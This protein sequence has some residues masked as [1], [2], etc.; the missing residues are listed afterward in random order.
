MKFTI[1]VFPRPD[2]PFRGKCAF[3]MQPV[4]LFE[5]HHHVCSLDIHKLCVCRSVLSPASLPP[6]FPSFKFAAVWSGSF[7]CSLVPRLKR[8]SSPCCLASTIVSIP[9]CL[10][11]CILRLQ[12]SLGPAGNT[13]DCSYCL[14]IINFFFTQLRRHVFKFDVCWSVHRRDK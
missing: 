13:V 2:S 14:E 9:L 8:H 10:R 12:T 7:A 3:H 11:K 6:T 5:G 1:T 4:S